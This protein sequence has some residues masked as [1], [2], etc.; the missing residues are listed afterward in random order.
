MTLYFSVFSLLKHYGT[1]NHG[2]TCSKSYHVHHISL[3]IYICYKLLL[4]QQG[5]PFKN[6]HI[7]D[8][9]FHRSSREQSL[10][11]NICP[12]CTLLDITFKQMTNIIRIY[13]Q[14]ALHRQC[15]DF[16]RSPRKAFIH[17]NRPRICFKSITLTSIHL[18]YFV[19]PKYW[20]FFCSLKIS[21]GLPL[22]HLEYMW[23]R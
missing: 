17:W 21:Y 3:Y 11:Q 22:Y 6:M 18:H 5:Q 23:C 4:L 1:V 8:V 20:L 15:I 9:C 14:K 7:T 2:V 10:Y 12:F 13:I 16:C 19:I